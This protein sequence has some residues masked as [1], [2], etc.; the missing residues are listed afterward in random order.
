SFVD[1]APTLLSLAGI[2]PPA[3]MQGHAFLGRYEAAPQSYLHGFRGRMDERYDLVRSVR[4]KRYVHIRNY[5]PHLLYGQHINYMF[6]TP[7]TRVWKQ[8]Y[9]AGRLNEAQ[10]RFWEP[11]PTE[12]LYDLHTD[13]D[14]VINLAQS[15]EHQEVLE[16]MRQAHREHLL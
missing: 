5:M 9:D 15:A 13:R 12:E 3:W 10:K 6:Q 11:K 16:R 2:E 4:D 14:E 8:L 1:L 7:T